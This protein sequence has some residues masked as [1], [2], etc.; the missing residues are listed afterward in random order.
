MTLFP[1]RALPVAL[2]AAMLAGCASRPVEPPMVAVT[3]TSSSSA[4]STT[5]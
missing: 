5:T 3:S 2:A 1:V 4:T